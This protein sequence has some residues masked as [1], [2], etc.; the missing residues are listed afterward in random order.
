MCAVSLSLNLPDPDLWGHVQYGRDALREGLPAT[1][2][3]TYTAEGYPWINHENL[4]ELL[5]A[6][7]M[8]AIGPAGMLATKMVLGLAVV[9]LILWHAYR[10]GVAMVGM[11]V[12]ALLVAA[13]MAPCWSMRPQL[14]TCVCYALL[15]ALLSWC[16]AGWEGGSLPLRPRCPAPGEPGSPG[17][18]SSRRLRYLWLA[19]VLFAVWANSHGGFVAGWCIYAAY[20][21]G[22][23][24]EALAYR[25]RAGI[26]LVQRFAL[27][28]TAAGLATL[29]NPYGP[30]LHRFLWEDLR[31]PRPEILEWRPPEIASVDMLPF[32]LLSLSGFFALLLTREKRD[33]TQAAI[34]LLAL[35]QSLLH[36]RHIPFLAIAFGFWMPVHVDSVLRRFHMVRGG[37]RFG[38]ENSPVVSVAFAVAMVLACGLLGVRL[39]G[40]LQ[41]MPVERDQYPVAALQ[42]MADQDLHGRMVV[43]FNWAQYAL[44]AFG[45]PRPDG[46]RILISFDGRYRTCFPQHVC[47]MNFD[48]VLGADEPR[49]RD[50][51]SPFDEGLALEYGRPDL[52]LINRYQPHSVQVMNRRRDRWTLLYQDKMAQLWGRAAR[53]GDPASEDYI[54]P[55]QRRI[56]DEEQKGSLPWPALPL[57]QPATR[58]LQGEAA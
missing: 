56:S 41:G 57:R 37:A 17:T 13:N 49:Y 5:M 35:W 53:Y 30:E 25:G 14:L 54:P 42:Y 24:I 2:T 28:I 10:R 4:A 40:R 8:D 23:S 36:Q 19:P 51:R 33:V 38:P 52:V 46:R 48:F 26:G 22:R 39:V 58:R 12:I 9:G 20:L 34:L 3:Y 55:S 15:L 50:P 18:F 7:G 43:T 29:L 27:M 47:D 32:G 44:A 45:P 21:A 6:W 16:F 31:V 1:A 11:C